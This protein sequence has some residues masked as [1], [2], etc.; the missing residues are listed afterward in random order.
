MLKEI[1]LVDIGSAHL[2]LGRQDMLPR[3]N[4]K[5][6]SEKLNRSGDAHSNLF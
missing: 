3:T 6:E 5:V 4:N 1:I 2:K